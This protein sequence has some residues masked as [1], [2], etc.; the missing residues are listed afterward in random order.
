V[1]RGLLLSKA[2]DP[3]VKLHAAAR[4]SKERL[5]LDAVVNSLID[6]GRK[7]SPAH[8]ILHK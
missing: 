4:F 2:L 7:F 6:A 5:Q 1:K 3:N 8:T